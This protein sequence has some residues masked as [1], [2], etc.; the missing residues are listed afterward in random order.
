VGAW[1]ALEPVDRQNGCLAV[2]PGSHR[3]GPLRHVNPDWEFLNMGYFA[4]EGVGAHPE[5]VHLEMQPGDTV[6][7]HPL[8]LHGSGRNRSAGYRRAISSR[9]AAASC[10]YPEGVDTSGNRRYRLIRG[11]VQ[12]GGILAP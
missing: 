3:G 4:A 10:R 11:R 5:R 2:V 9:F 7:F 1:T 8:L 6:F 12:P